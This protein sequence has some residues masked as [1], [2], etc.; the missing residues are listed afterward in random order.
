MFE[1]YSAIQSD[2]EWENDDSHMLLQLASASFMLWEF[3]GVFQ[4]W[5]TPA[6]LLRREWSKA[7]LTFASG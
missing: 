7:R 3:G 4:V 6:A 5:I 2:A 1:N